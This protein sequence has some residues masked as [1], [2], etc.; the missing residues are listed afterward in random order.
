MEDIAEQEKLK[1]YENRVADWIGNQGILFQLRYA[2]TIGANSI[3]KQ[4]GSLIVK[5]AIVLVLV[6]GVGYLLLTQHFKGEAYEAEIQ[7]S[8]EEALGLQGLEVKG[9]ARARGNGGFHRLQLDGGEESFFYHAKIMDLNAPFTYSTGVTTAWKPSSLKMARAQFHF[10]A[11]G[12]V[13]EM[14]DAYSVVLESLA[15]EG[16]TSILIEDFSCDWGYSK[17]TYG[18]I[19]QARLRA[20]LNDGKWNIILTG[21]TY[22]QNWLCDFAIAEGHLILDGDG[23]EVVSLKMAQDNGELE[24]VGKIGGPL[25]MPE[26]NLSGAFKDLAIENMLTVSGE[27][28]REFIEGLISG[29]L[30]ISGSTNRRIQIDGSVALSKTNSL[31]IRERWPILKAV[32]IMDTQRT[33]RRVDFT[34][35]SFQFSTENGN[36]AVSD[37]NLVAAD[38]AILKGSFVTRLPDQEEAAKFL[39]ITLT[40]GF[41]S[42]AT[43]TSVSQKLE[44]ERMSLRDILREGNQVDDV[45]PDRSLSRSSQDEEAVLSGQA[46][47]E[48]LLRAEMCNHWVDGGLELGVPASSFAEHARLSE[49]YPADEAGWRWIEIEL[50]DTHFTDISKMANETVLKLARRRGASE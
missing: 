3:L 28:T 6:A 4:L 32:S 39:E 5:F 30:K 15:G 45:Y 47:D 49:A 38:T 46:P 24:L 34:E 17:L 8:I 16:V 26:F 9:F 35:G 36:L 29:D 11:G 40:E 41:S 21:G 44:D 13:A 10:K 19:G 50:A 42:D 43:D 22:Q 1:D 25:D 27:T 48:L 18:R 37:I 20:N 12:T 23:I 2:R 33:F 31:T 7:G 14:E